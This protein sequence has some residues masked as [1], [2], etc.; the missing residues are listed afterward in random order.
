M[1][2]KIIIQIESWS[3]YGETT[4]EEYDGI[5][6]QTKE[7]AQKKANKANQESPYIYAYV[8]EI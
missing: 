3:I 8:K 5:I 2:Y 1:A 6:Y 4:T 7:E